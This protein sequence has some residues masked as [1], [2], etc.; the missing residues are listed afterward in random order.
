MKRLIKFAVT[1]ILLLLV[2]LLASDA[3][4][5][6]SLKD[7]LMGTWTFVTSVDLQKDGTKAPDRWGPNAKGIL[8]F[9]PNGRYVLVINRADLPKFAANRVDQGTADE[10]GAV[11]KGSIATF[12]TYS[13]NEAEKTVTTR[14]EG[15]SYP[16]LYGVN[17]KRTITSLT[18]EE[19][20][21]TNPATATGVTAQVTWKRA[22]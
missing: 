7:Q 2:A 5:Q 20:K 18:A 19:L 10:N 6:K 14:V 16:N 15:G 17:Q 12:G 11:M 3:F 13:V 9:D 22:K 4:S 1:T 21:Y 8:I